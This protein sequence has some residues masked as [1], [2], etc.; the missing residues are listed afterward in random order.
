MARSTFL[1]H[2][3]QLFK[4]RSQSDFPLFNLKL[5]V[6]KDPKQ[7]LKIEKYF[8]QPYSLQWLMLTKNTHDT[9]FR[10]AFLGTSKRSEL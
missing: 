7:G 6:K 8:M 9:V 2:F 5:N 4:E 3:Q 1:C 10:A